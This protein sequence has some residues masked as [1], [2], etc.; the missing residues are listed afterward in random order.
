[1]RPVLVSWV[2]NSSLLPHRGTFIWLILY[3]GDPQQHGGAFLRHVCVVF[4]FLVAWE[5]V[6][7]G[8]NAIVVK[9]LAPKR[10]FCLL[11]ELHTQTH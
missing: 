8:E 1:M 2:H 9:E 4:I 5:A 10:G 7:N 3:E 11:P 6:Q